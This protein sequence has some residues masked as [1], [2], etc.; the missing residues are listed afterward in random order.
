MKILYGLGRRH[1]SIFYVLCSA[2]SQIVKRVW[3]TATS[4][5]VNSIL[6]NVSNKCS[7]LGNGDTGRGKKIQ[8]HFSVYISI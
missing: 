7:Q 4:K 8:V 3:K 5:R 6:F 2:R 1:W